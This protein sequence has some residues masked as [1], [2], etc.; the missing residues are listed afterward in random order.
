MIGFS[1]YTKTTRLHWAAVAK[2]TV[3]MTSAYN[4]EAQESSMWY[5]DNKVLHWDCDPKH[6]V[7]SG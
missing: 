6:Y 7:L 2:I 3:A 5:G 4:N 1:E